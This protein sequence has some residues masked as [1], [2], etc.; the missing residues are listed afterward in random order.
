MY[1]TRA[2][3]DANYY[4]DRLSSDDPPPP[5]RASLVW[6]LLLLVLETRMTSDGW[7]GDLPCVLI[8]KPQFFHHDM[9]LK[10]DARLRKENKLEE[11][12]GRVRFPRK[13]RSWQLCRT[14]LS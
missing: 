4:Y 6:T 8:F 13:L 11:E 9:S 5:P 10:L 12:V 7:V 1:E 14:R 3:L 2:V